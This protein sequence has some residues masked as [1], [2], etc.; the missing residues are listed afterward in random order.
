MNDSHRASACWGKASTRQKSPTAP[1]ST[2]TFPAARR[3]RT[4][5]WPRLS[6]RAR[7]PTPLFSVGVSLLG[8]SIESAEIANGTIVPA[9]VNTASFSNTFWGMGG[10]A[11]TNPTNGA[12]LGTTDNQPLEIKV[13]G[14][15]ALRIE[16]PTNFFGDIPNIVGG[17]S[18]NIVS[19]GFVGAV[20]GGG[21]QPGSPNRVGNDFATVVGGIANTAS[22][23]TS[24]A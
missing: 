16:A 17:H 8:Q 6:R 19:N 9:D 15:R 24:T 12:F 1:S 3:S 7:W 5:S 18:V 20:I 21:G 11:G 23:T 22:G 14:V 13:N 10:N 2:P 4:P